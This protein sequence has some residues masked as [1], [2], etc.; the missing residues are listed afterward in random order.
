MDPI[1]AALARMPEGCVVTDPDI[2]ASRTLD[3]RKLYQGA[4]RA[5]LRPASVEEVQAIVRICAEEGIP[6]VP[7]GG[8]TGYCT[9]ATPDA[10][11]AELI[12]SLERMSR[13]REI[14]PANLSLSADAGAI[15][16]DLQRAA[17]DAGLMLPLALGSQASCRI[18]GNLSTNA[19]G[20]QVL[21]YGMAR[22]IVLGIE[23][24]LPDGSLVS[25]MAPLRKNNAGYD[26]KQLFIGAEGTLG[27]I[28][29]VS[30]ALVRQ[31]RQVVT[32]MLAVE[33]ITRLPEL[34]ARAQ[35]HSG[36]QITSFEYVSRA[37][38]DLLLSSHAELAHPLPGDAAHYILMEAATASPV[39]WLE[40]AM[41][42][43]LGEMIEEGAVTD[44]IIATSG[45]QRTSLWH[46]RENIPEGEVRHGGSVK[47]DVAVRCS[48]VAEFIEAARD[49]VT[50]LCPE[51]RQ[52]IYGHVGDGNV[53]FNLLAPQGVDPK[54]FKARIEAELSPAI[55]QLAVDMGGTF[56]AEYG[57]GRVKMDMLRQFG[58]PGK[59]DLM[60]RIKRA[61][62]PQGLMNPGKVVVD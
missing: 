21:R 60:G 59:R 45:Q 39:P 8:N 52:S 56:S 18:G 10:G 40:D 15:L 37:S 44:G 34:L 35:G 28:T 27:I 30:L 26:V 61:I 12:V 14:D 41:T 23:V 62:D 11:G 9:A 7:Q 48:R 1:S 47:H 55:H 43:L 17:E 58:H 6:L 29:G 38:L 16:S 24:V 54:A 4:A 49:L 19:G 13:L 32:A 2:I 25:E 31:P 33:D 3:F 5:L 50:R 20:I 36:E 42:A 53:H 22:A 46:L 51:A 57:I